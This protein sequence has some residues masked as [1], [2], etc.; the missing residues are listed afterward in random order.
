MSTEKYLKIPVLAP[1][2]GEFICTFADC[3][4]RKRNEDIFTT[5]RADAAYHGM[6]CP[7]RDH[8]PR[9][10]DHTICPHN[11]HANGIS[12]GCPGASFGTM[13]DGAVHVM[14]CESALLT[15]KCPRGFRR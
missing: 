4:D 8:S 1:A 3:P 9:N 6:L 12:R 5:G 2:P 11:L 10:L 15:G 14:W 13:Q 7:M